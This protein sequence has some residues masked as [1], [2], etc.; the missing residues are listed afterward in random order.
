MIDTIAAILILFFLFALIVQDIKF[1]TISL[2]NILGLALCALWLDLF[3]VWGALSGGVV[4]TGLLMYIRYVFK[5]PISQCMGSGDI[6]FLMFISSITPLPQ[7]SLLLSLSG[8]LGVILYYLFNRQYIPLGAGIA[9]A[10]G[11]LI[12]YF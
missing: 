12:F 9:G 11:I 10:Y 1:Y 5:R 2:Y 8:A 6:V 3:C 7:I 4:L